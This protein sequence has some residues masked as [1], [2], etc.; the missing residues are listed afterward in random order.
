MTS[1]ALAVPLTRYE[2]SVPQ[3]PRSHLF[4]CLACQVAFSTAEQ[5]RTH[6][7]TDWHRYNLKRKVADLP[8][9]SDDV[10][11][12]KVLAQQAQN[13]TENARANFSAEC[14]ICSKTYS[15]ENAYTNHLQSNRHKI[16]EGKVGQEGIKQSRPSSDATTTTIQTQPPQNGITEETTEAEI[17]AIVDKKIA[18]SLKLAEVDCLFCPRK[19]KSFETNIEH[20]TKTHGFFIPELE[21]V[22][23]LR[24]LIKYLGEKITVG[25][26]CLL[27]NGRGKGMKSLEAV[28]K[29]M[30]DKGHCMIAYER[31]E[32][33]LDLGEYYDFTSTYP[34]EE[35]EDVEDG[36]DEDGEIID[37][38]IS[39]SSRDLTTS[40]IVLY[41]DNETE[42]VLPSGAR[43]GHRSLHRYYKQYLRP[44]EAREPV[45]VNRLLTHYTH[46]LGYERTMRTYNLGPAA[47]RRGTVN[48]E[49]RCQHEFDTRIGIKANKLQRHFR[50]QIL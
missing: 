4:T 34:D 3:K 30:I 25:N 12:Q 42:L 45:I 21:Y 44:R 28:R 10:F 13:N 47:A 17:Q 18:L 7:G 50:A 35:W 49:K 6:Y 16:A 48:K 15:S 1:A 2:A 22:T 36:E 9:I 24:G 39:V 26:I 38:E 14:S 41:T 8:P 31:E 23:D 29:H 20:M 43:L 19:S 33:I 40:T 32:D 27:C 37:E 11:S 46:N 5:Q